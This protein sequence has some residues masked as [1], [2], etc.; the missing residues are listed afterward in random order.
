M[1]PVH[2]QARNEEEEPAYKNWDEYEFAKWLENALRIA[3]ECKKRETRQMKNDDYEV[4]RIQLQ[5]PPKARSNPFISAPL[6]ITAGETGAVRIDPKLRNVKFEVDGDI[7]SAP[8]KKRISPPAMGVRAVNQFRFPDSPAEF[9]MSNFNVAGPSSATDSIV[10]PLEMKTITPGLRMRTPSGNT[11]KISLKKEE[12]KQVLVISEQEIVPPSQEIGSTNFLVPA[13]LTANTSETFD[14]DWEVINVESDFRLGQHTQ[15]RPEICMNQQWPATTTVRAGLPPRM[16]Y[17]T[18]PIDMSANPGVGPNVYTPQPPPQAMVPHPAISR[19]NN[20][21]GQ[22]SLGA[23]RP[24]MALPAPQPKV[25]PVFGS[26]IRSRLGADAFQFVHTG[27]GLLTDLRI[28]KAR[29]LVDTGADVSIITARYASRTGLRVT[30]FDANA[31]PPVITQADSSQIAWA[32]FAEVGTYIAGAVWPHNFYVTSTDFN[33][34]GHYDV[35]M[36][37]DL[38]GKIGVL[39]FSRF[40]EK[41]T[42]LAG[43]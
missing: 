17:R 25:N 34:G 21:F 29:I 15:D 20:Q 36:G 16:I 12:K 23:P 1:P 14:F 33:V 35:I 26:Q 40:P 19:V 27:L 10:R 6:P 4:P 5:A 8:P 13:S 32:G 28:T 39:K 41:G 43:Y 38:I 42:A 7:V 22:M 31:P 9:S 3:N 2:V 37:T 11:R 30:P 24:Q 18:N